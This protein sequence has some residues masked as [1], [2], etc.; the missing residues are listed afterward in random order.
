[1]QIRD[2]ADIRY[3]EMRHCCAKNDAG[4]SLALEHHVMDDIGLRWRYNFGWCSRLEVAQWLLVALRRLSHLCS[5]ERQERQAGH[6]SNR[7]DQVDL[8]KELPL[9]ARSQYRGNVSAA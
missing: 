8:R 3:L 5:A 4:H 6:L 1:M 9:L 7:N 2:Q